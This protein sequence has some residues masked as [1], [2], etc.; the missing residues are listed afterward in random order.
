MY[1][2]FTSNTIPFILH[3]FCFHFI[4][5]SPPS[6]LQFSFPLCRSLFTFPPSF[7]LILSLHLFLHRRV[8]LPC[9]VPSSTPFF[10]LFL[11]I[12]SLL[13]STHISLVSSF[14][15]SLP[16]FLLLPFHFS[17]YTPSSFST[18][19]A[20]ISS[21]PSFPSPYLSSFILPFLPNVYNLLLFLSS[22]HSPN[23]FFTQLSFRLFLSTFLCTSSS[24]LPFLF[25]LSPV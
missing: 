16:F 14:F 9:S 23:Y 18:F 22:S 4:H 24:L 13:T 1:S 21:L 11:P 19:I 12:F 7:P 5:L 20:V 8:S 2:T 17:P 3:T 10:L 15:L 25:L 6:P